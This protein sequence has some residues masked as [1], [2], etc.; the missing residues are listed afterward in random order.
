MWESVSESGLEKGNSPQEQ[1]VLRGG[2]VY[3]RREDEGHCLD[4]QL[5]R[6]SSCPERD[7]RWVKIRG[8][9]KVRVSEWWQWWREW[10]WGR[11]GKG[12]TEECTRQVVKLICTT[13]YTFYTFLKEIHVISKNKSTKIPSPHPRKKQ[14]NQVPHPYGDFLRTPDSQRDVPQCPPRP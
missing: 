13:S 14:T 5:V 1:D 9:N 10:E 2:L 11:K 7:M 6:F 12:G 4:L 8:A 3:R